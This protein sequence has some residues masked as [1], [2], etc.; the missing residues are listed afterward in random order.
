M[1]TMLSAIAERNRFEIVEYL[2]DGPRSVNE[3][4]GKTKLRQPQVS[5]HLRVLSEA[6]IVER[7]ATAQLRIYSLN[8]LTFRELDRWVSTFKGI[9]SDRLDS[10][11]DYLQGL[12]ATRRVEPTTEANST[13]NREDDI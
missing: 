10:L 8:P 12:K 2:R 9:W 7:H 3:I 6:G 5:K 4:V 11:D 13:G 1:V